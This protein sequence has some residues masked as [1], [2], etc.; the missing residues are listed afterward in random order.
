MPPEMKPAHG[1]YGVALVEIALVLPVFLAV[2]GGLTALGRAASVTQALHDSARL[3]VR[4]AAAP[5]A[6]NETIRSA[7]YEALA[8]ST[9]LSA[10]DV[11][12]TI[13]IEIAP[14]NESP[15]GEIAKTH[16]KDRIRVAINVPCERISW[17]SGLVF[18]GTPLRGESQ[19]CR[20]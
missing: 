8:T 15:E 9:G 10:Q 2:V 13:H 14:G 4:L 20:E 7:V 5:G 1:R 17:L 19:I 3:G 18:Q 6:T 16:P 12:L 11:T